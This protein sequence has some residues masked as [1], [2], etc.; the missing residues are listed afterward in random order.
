M[1]LAVVDRAG[2]TQTGNVRRSNEDAFLI[3]EP[4]FLVADGVGGAQAGEIAAR[5]CAQEFADLDLAELDGETGMRAAIARAN[6]HIHERARSDAALSGM[7]TTVAA[8]LFRGDQL[9]VAN[10]GD[11]RTYLLRDGALQRLSHDHSLVGE[12]VRAGELTEAD[13]E[14]HPQRSVITRVLGAGPEVE[15]DIVTVPARDGDVVLVCSDGLN[16]MIDD[17]AIGRLLAAERPVQEI[18]RDLVRAALTAGGEDNVTTVVFRIGSGA[19]ADDGTPAAVQSGEAAGRSPLRAAVRAAA[20]V[21]AVAVLVAAAVAG[22][23]WSHFVGADRASGRV[24]IY[25]GIPLDLPFGAHLYRETYLSPVAYATLPATE[26]RS[27]FDQR[28]RSAASA[29]QAVAK[30]EA[31]SP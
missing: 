16:S 11:S 27:L 17:A 23:R 14:R 19:A 10:V 6:L 24:A 8:V 30:V 15:A 21:L 9:T 28:L 7:G 22:L 1:A 2:V 3:R 25:Q 26:R 18:A 4:L 20:A 29:R 5:M 13:A 31:S 12:M